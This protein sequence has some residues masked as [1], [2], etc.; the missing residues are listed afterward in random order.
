MLKRTF[1]AGIAGVFLFSGSAFA[2]DF[3][4]DQPIGETAEE[5]EKEVEEAAE[6]TQE[7]VIPSE[8]QARGAAPGNLALELG[9]GIADFNGN[10]G[11]QINAGPSW[12]LRGI[13]GANRTIGGEIAYVGV[14]SNLDGQDLISNEAVDGTALTS[15]GD[16]SARFN[17]LSSEFIQPFATAGLGVMGVD[18]RDENTTVDKGTALTIP[19]GAGVQIYTDS[20]LT[21]G[22]RVNYRILTDIIDNDLPSGDNWNLGVNVGATF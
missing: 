8:P 3:D 14:A 10:L 18:V 6:D 5:L 7:A 15:A 21:F 11:D 20:A 16:V 22:A 1:A 9:L 13:F 2:Q 19:V 12:D 17:A 4:P